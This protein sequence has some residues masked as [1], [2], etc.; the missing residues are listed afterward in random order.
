MSTRVAQ[1]S[2]WISTGVSTPGPREVI[3]ATADWWSPLP[4]QPGRV[5]HY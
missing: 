1:C 3:D 2:S 5:L 4:G